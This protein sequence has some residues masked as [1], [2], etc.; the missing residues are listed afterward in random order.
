M[1]I[2]KILLQNCS[3]NRQTEEVLAHTFIDN[4][5]IYSKLYHYLF[6]VGHA[7]EKTYDELCF[8]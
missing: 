8:Y 4:W 5:N 6:V 2:F 1:R 7:L 3:Y